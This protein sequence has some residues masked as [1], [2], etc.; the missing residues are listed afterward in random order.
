MIAVGC[1]GLRREGF[2]RDSGRLLCI[3]AM[4]VLEERGLDVGDSVVGL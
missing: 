4:D 1:L 2:T 3:V